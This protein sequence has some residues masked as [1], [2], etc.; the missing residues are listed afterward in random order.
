MQEKDTAVRSGKKNSRHLP[1]NNGMKL[2]EK[3]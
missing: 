1:E 2:K 3:K